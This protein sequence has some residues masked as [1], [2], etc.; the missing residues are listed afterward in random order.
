MPPPTGHG[1]TPADTSPGISLQGWQLSAGA[2]NCKQ[3]VIKH[4]PN[5]PQRLPSGCQGSAAGRWGTCPPRQVETSPARRPREVKPEPGFYPGAQSPIPST[6]PAGVSGGIATDQL[7]S[8]LGQPQRC[9]M[10]TLVMAGV[11][12]GYGIPSGAGPSEAL[13]F[14]PLVAPSW[15]LGS[16]HHLWRGRTPW[17]TI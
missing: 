4:N 7:L 10:A 16:S 2:A 12:W 1:S 15:D 11:S 9:L 8:H 3:G 5:S 13:S 14:L 17:K 6:C